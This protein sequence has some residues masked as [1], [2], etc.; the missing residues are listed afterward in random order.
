MISYGRR[1]SK[2]RRG[3]RT[4]HRQRVNALIDARKKWPRRAGFRGGWA[5]LDWE[6]NHRQGGHT[7]YDRQHS[8]SRPRVR[9]NPFLGNSGTSD[10]RT[11]PPSGCTR[12]SMRSRRAHQRRAKSTERKRAAIRL[13]ARPTGTVSSCR[14]PYCSKI[15]VRRTA[16]C[17]LCRRSRPHRRLARIFHQKHEMRSAES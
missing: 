4:T 8:R 7:R 14:H 16:L 12:L 1:P 13:E 17:S 15:I 9:S 5:R 6:L 3:T 11:R 2:R 10:V